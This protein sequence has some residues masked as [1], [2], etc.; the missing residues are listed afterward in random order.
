[1]RAAQ[2]AALGLAA[3]AEQDEIL[4]RQN[5]VDDLRNDCVFK[6]DDAGE[7]RLLRLEP[8]NQVGAH[9]VFDAAG[10]QACFGKLSAAAQFPQGLGKRVSWP[11]NGSC[12]RPDQNRV[13][14]YCRRAAKAVGAPAS[15]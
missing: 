7:E 4:P 1:M 14:S 5:R 12:V 10:L 9:L 3:Q 2:D 13:C 11:S 6:A 15:C 8:G